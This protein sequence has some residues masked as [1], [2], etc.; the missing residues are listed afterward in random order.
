[1]NGIV[2]PVSF[3]SNFLLLVHWNQLTEGFNIRCKGL[4][5]IL[6]GYNHLI[7][8]KGYSYSFHHYFRSIYF[9]ASS[10]WL[11]FQVLQWRR[12]QTMHKLPP[13]Q[14]L[15]EMLPIP[16]IQCKICCRVMK[17]SLFKYLIITILSWDFRV[18]IM[19]G[20]WYFSKALLESIRMTVW[21]FFCASV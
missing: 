11:V 12:E 1:M 7:Y 5:R 14:S 2:F 18:F 9:L 20:C 3:S 8:K 10:L 16:P 21:F 13:L 4:W 19:K 6:Y 17:C 15:G